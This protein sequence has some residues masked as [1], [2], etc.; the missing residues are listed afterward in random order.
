VVVFFEHGGHHGVVH[1]HVELWY[2]CR[3][4]ESEFV[5]GW[6][7]VALCVIGVW[8]VNGVD[9][10]DFLPWYRFQSS[11]TRGHFDEAVE[12]DEEFRDMGG[13]NSAKDIFLTLATDFLTEAPALEHLFLK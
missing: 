11:T 8:W 4:F 1:G 13:N 9:L 12:D 3:D 6:H 5:A 7:V 10:Y 2:F